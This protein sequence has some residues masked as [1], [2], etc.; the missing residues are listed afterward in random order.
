LGIATQPSR[1]DIDALT[2][3]DHD[4]R[5]GAKLRAV[6]VDVRLIEEDAQ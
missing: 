5:T 6:L 1:K 4:A 2:G 3:I